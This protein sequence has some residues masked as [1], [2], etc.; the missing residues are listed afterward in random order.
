MSS[1]SPAAF[2]TLAGSR[3]SGRPGDTT[4]CGDATD[5]DGRI[6]GNR[7]VAPQAASAI[8]LAADGRNNREQVVVGEKGVR[9]T[10]RSARVGPSVAEAVA[11]A[12][13]GA[14]KG[15]RDRRR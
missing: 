13:E 1:A 3:L 2:G 4:P 10:E 14:R 8:D 6:A 7:A 15:T 11:G 9:V 5:E 12:A